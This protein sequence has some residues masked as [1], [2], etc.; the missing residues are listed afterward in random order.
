[1]CN[2]KGP[3]KAPSETK[4]IINTS[5]FSS[6]HAESKAWPLCDE[7]WLEGFGDEPCAPL[8]GE[9]DVADAYEE[10]PEWANEARAFCPADR[11][12]PLWQ[13]WPLWRI[14]MRLREFLCAVVAQ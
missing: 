6:Q 13:R 5:T 2:E 8:E 9:Y 7:E 14:W 1:M 11:P 3:G 12:A 10:W 4:P